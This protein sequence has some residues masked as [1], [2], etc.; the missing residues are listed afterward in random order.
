MSDDDLLTLDGRRVLRS[1]AVPMTLP[2]MITVVDT[3]RTY[4]M[5]SPVVVS[6]CGWSA[7]PRTH[8][9]VITHSGPD[10]FLVSGRV[11]R[12]GNTDG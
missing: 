3:M 1:Q 8:A 7:L 4:Q 12:Q 2:H 5:V 6:R 10:R 9:E 11:G